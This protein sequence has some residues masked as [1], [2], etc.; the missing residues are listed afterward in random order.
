[1]WSTEVPVYPTPGDP[2]QMAPVRHLLPPN[3]WVS[4]KD[5]V[6][7]DQRVWYRIEKEEYVLA[8]DVLPASPSTFHGVAVGQAYH[9]PFGF[10][11]ADQLNSRARPGV[12]PDNPPLELLPRY[13]V[14][15]I[16]GQETTSDGVWY[17]ISSDRYVHSAYARVVTATPRPGDVAP[18]EKWIAVNLSEQTLAAYEGD[19]MVFATL[20]RGYGLHA[21]YWHDG[22]GSPRSHGCVNLSP[23]DARWLF[24]WA[25]PSL[26]EGRRAVLSK[27]DNPG[28]WVYVYSTTADFALA[29]V[30]P[31]AVP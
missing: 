24:D 25:S 7:M 23:R 26:P 9:P 20:Y 8:S 31:L 2:V 5:E 19:Q 18:D 27:E 11:V 4:I 14:V 12:T 22:F 13:T 29:H 10:V 17:Q 30:L 3:T 15:D 28:T 6:Q 16:L 21:A 1:V